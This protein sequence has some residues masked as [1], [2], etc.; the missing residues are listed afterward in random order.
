MALLTYEEYL[1][2]VAEP[3]VRTARILREE[4][5]KRFEL[6]LFAPGR[7]QVLCSA[8]GDCLQGWAKVYEAL[9]KKILHK[10]PKVMPGIWWAEHF[11]VWGLK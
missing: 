11:G 6:Q 9:E 7:E 10:Y 5:H 3:A 4:R 1:K 2:E 8:D